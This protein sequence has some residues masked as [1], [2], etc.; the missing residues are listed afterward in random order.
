MQLF[1]VMGI[2]ISVAFLVLLSGFTL[3]V[4]LSISILVS[5]VAVDSYSTYRSLKAGGTEANPIVRFLFKRIGFN[6]T[7]VLVWIAWALIIHFKVI[8]ALPQQQT[9]LALAYWVIPVN[10]FLVVWK[11]KQRAKKAAEST[12]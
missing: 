12:T 9:A 10:N 4:G 8:T 11:Y 1:L 5:A 7:L 6:A 2:F 3:P